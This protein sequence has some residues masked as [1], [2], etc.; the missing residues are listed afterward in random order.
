MQLF[1]ALALGSAVSALIPTV[2]SGQRP[3]EPVC[4]R[5]RGDYRACAF[6]AGHVED[7]RDASFAADEREIRFWTVSGILFP[8]EV[9]LIHQRGDTVTGK[10]LLIWADSTVSDT[11]AKSRCTDQAWVTTTGSLCVGRLASPPDWASLLRELDAAGLQQLPGNPAPE[12][13]C[14]MSPVAARAGE[15]PRDR[16]CAFVED[17]FSHYLEVKTAS[18]YWRYLFQRLPDTTSTVLARDRAIMRLFRCAG[19]AARD[20]S[21]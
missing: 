9:L 18:V 6:S 12:R 13:P 4:D 5:P 11:L 21:C 14:D 19:N 10:L 3:G 16:T 20:T 7:L 1:R 8:E 2:G 15:P 17:G